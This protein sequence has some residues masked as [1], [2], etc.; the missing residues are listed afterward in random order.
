MDEFNNN[1]LTQNVEDEISITDKM[2]GVL[3]EPSSL[4]QKLSHQKPKVL[5]W[6]FPI[7][8]LIIVSSVSRFI[9]MSNPQIKADAIEKQM[10]LVE[11]NIQEAVDKGNLSQEKA[12]E[13][14]EKSRESMEKGGSLQQIL[15][16]VGTLISIFL[17]FFI[18][19]AIFYLVA[20]I[21]L[22]G[23]GTYS[24]AMV[25]YGL[26]FYILVIQ[27]IVIIIIS[28]S[29]NKMFIDT[30][31]GSFLGMENNT[32]IGLLAHKLDIFSIW[33][34]AVVSIAFAKMFKSENTT[35]YLI[36]FFALWI[37]FG[38]L[39]FFAGKAIPF[40]KLFNM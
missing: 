10:A 8:F 24:D 20:K 29:M 23:T 18:L 37:G 38:I 33:F 16:V 30:S 2:V 1:D 26:P 19:S 22:G 5:D 34:Y 3:T 28:M 40:M 21:T 7:L 17:M 27:I 39:M 15:T 25:A 4:F 11:K 13:I 36:T 31:V 9:L 14:L 6:V 35:K 32:L 12:D